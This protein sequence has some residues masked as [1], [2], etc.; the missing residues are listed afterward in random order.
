MKIT[1]GIMGI[2]SLLLAGVSI[3]SIIRISKSLKD[4][5]F[6]KTDNEEIIVE[7]HEVSAIIEAADNE[8]KLCNIEITTKIK[9]N[10]KFYIVTVVMGHVG[11]NKKII[12]KLAII[13]ENGHEASAIARQTPRVKHDQKFAIIDCTEVTQEKYQE[14]KS[15]N[16]ADL[17]FRCINRQQQRAL[18]LEEEA[19]EEELLE[20]KFK[21]NHSLRKTFFYCPKEIERLHGDIKDIEIA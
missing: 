1:Y 3:S 21:K 10:K 20:E 13:A 17:Y 18:G 11:R 19:I 15:I 6:K 12:K 4:L 9:S 2:A 5:N 16:S 8:K 14:Q 7:P